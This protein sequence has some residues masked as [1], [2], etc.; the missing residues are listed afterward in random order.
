MRYRKWRPNEILSSGKTF[1]LRKLTELLLPVRVI[2]TFRE[3]QPTAIAE[4]FFKLCGET[5]TQITGLG[6]AL[7]AY[8]TIMLCIILWYPVARP[9][10]SAGR[11]EVN[12]HQSC[13]LQVVS[14]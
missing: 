1:R 4:E 10:E 8:D 9:G 7:F 6:I 12:K 2:R 5:S 14:S 11:Q 3:L 13:G